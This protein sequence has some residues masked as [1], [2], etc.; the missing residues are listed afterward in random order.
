VSI[1]TP[2]D[3][4]ALEAARAAATPG[5]WRP[6]GEHLIVDE[7]GVS[8]IA[9]QVDDADAALI[10]AAVNALPDLLDEVRWGRALREAVEGLAEAIADEAVD[11]IWYRD[12]LKQTAARIAA[13]APQQRE[14][15]S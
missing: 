6:H 4:D 14:D 13:L 5:P 2:K 9:T 10:V 12:V 8:L 3:V 11:A 15:D 7:R 1:H